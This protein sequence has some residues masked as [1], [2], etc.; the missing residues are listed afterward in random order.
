MW[1]I[2]N[3]EIKNRLVLA[4]MAG[5]S[6]SSF[7][8]ICKKYGAGLI[9]AEMVSDKALVYENKKTYDMLYMEEEERPIVQQIFGSDPQSMA[10]AARII[11]KEMKPDI[12]DINFGCPVKKVAIKSGGGSGLLKNPELVYEITKSVVEAVKTPVTAKIRIGWDDNNING[13]EVAKL[14]E[15]AGVKAI[16]VHGRTRAAFYRGKSNWEMIKKI[17]ESVSIPVIGNGDITSPEIAKELLE[18]SG[19][20]ALM[21]GRAAIGRPWI[22]KQINEYLEKG[23]YEEIS[24][25]DKFKV[26]YEHIDNLKKQKSDRLAAIEMRSFIGAYLKGIKGSKQTKEEI[27]KLETIND[28]MNSLKNLEKAIR[29]RDEKI[30]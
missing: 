28:I 16:T 23:T 18:Y 25:E 12:I 11:E 2:D 26:I 29:G 3:I 19:V 24:I 30:N 10:E 27:F 17:K 4:P 20:D 8:R 5:F 7:R 15:K 6:N 22:F 1:K 14:L 21:I 9:F 13:T